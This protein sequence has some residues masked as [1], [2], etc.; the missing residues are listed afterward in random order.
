GDD[1]F[2]SRRQAD[3]S[4]GKAV[5]IGYPINSPGN[6]QAIIVNASGDFAY[7]TSDRPGGY[8]DMDIYSF[9]LYTQARPNPVTYLKGIVQDKETGQKLEAIFEL[10][11]L[12]T[13]KTAITYASDKVNGSFLV[14][15]PTNQDYALNV[16][17]SGYLF[18]SE[19][20]TLSGTNNISEPFEKIIE[21]SP[22]HANKSV[23]LKNIFFET[24]EFTLLEP[25]KAELNKLVEF[26][27]QN[28]SLKIEIGGHTDNVGSDDLNKKLSENRAKAVYEYLINAGID[29][30]RL[31]YKG[32]GSTKPI[33]PNNTDVGRAENRRTEFKIIQ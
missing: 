15:L 4:W 25:S 10:I 2:Y 18:Y 32:Y 27:T 12:S 24:N 23:V 31:S 14:A 8:G 30:A 19:N 28:N 33:A 26:L 22:I 5:N 29:K 3:G 17:K 9:D 16:S 21:L 6:E 11:N 1:I 20:F 13:T 7:I